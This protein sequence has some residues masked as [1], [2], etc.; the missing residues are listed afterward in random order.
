MSVSQKPGQIDF[1]KSH[2]SSV[3]HYLV[4]Q[5]PQC[6]GREVVLAV[7][8]TEGGSCLTSLVML[9]QVLTVQ[10]PVQTESH[11]LQHRLMAYGTQTA[12]GPELGLDEQVVSLGQQRRESGMPISLSKSLVGLIQT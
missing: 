2:M 7:Y 5:H 6:R 1:R 4:A 8:Q 12:T 10:G 3:V 11:Q 9:P